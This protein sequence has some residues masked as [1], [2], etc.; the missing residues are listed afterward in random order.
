MKFQVKKTSNGQFRFNLVAPNGQVV[1]TSETYERK[2]SALDTI[3]SIKKN[4]GNADIDDST[5]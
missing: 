5:A 4:A 3:A 1:A 2:Q